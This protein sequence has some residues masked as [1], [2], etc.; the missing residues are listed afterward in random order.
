MK[1]SLRCCALF[2]LFG[3]SASAAIVDFAAPEGKAAPTERDAR[4]KGGAAQTPLFDLSPLVDK[5]VAEKFSNQYLHNDL[6]VTLVGPASWSER[7]YPSVNNKN[8]M[9]RLRATVDALPA[10]APF[11]LPVVGTR[12]DA[13][14]IRAAL[15]AMTNALPDDVYQVLTRKKALAPVMQWMIRRHLPGV[16]KDADYLGPRAHPVAF[17]PSH[18]EVSALTNAAARMTLATVPPIVHVMSVYDEYERDPIPRTVPGRDFADFQPEE[19]FSTPFAISVVLRAPELKRRFRFCARTWADS[20]RRFEYAWK[21][22]RGRGL[23]RIDSYRGNGKLKP[24]HGFAEVILNRRDL[25]QRLDLAVFSRVPGGQWGP[26]AIISFYQLP[27]LRQ[28]YYNSGHLRETS[29]LPMADLAD[30][31]RQALR[32]IYVPRNWV[33]T[34]EVDDKGDIQVISRRRASSV[35]AERL[36]RKTGELLLET[37][38]S[39]APRKTRPVE[40]FVTTDGLLDYRAHGKVV[41]HEL[42]K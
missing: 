33:D 39:G 32:P 35:F 37:W 13:A 42:K 7:P 9:P 21:V 29:Y 24:V 23:E 4:G 22:L 28:E 27:D 12:E 15:T 5:Q 31:F 26:P 10:N 40:Y 16:S 6:A 14:Q 19:T 34:Y 30:P 11:Y 18:F 20:G 25:S 3:F 8:P 41:V 36:S 17:M 2:I 38:G 1:N